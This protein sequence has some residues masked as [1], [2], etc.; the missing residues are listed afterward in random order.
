MYLNIREARQFP[1]NLKKPLFRNNN[2]GVFAYQVGENRCPHLGFNDKKSFCNIYENR[3]LCCKTFPVMDKG[4]GEVELSQ[5]CTV[6]RQNKNAVFSTE[7][8]K[9]EI[10]ALEEQKR[11]M[12]FIPVAQ[13]MYLFKIDKWIKYGGFKTVS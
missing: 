6:V 10:Q 2:D 12:D 9:D 11:E 3:P 13:E 7:S 4:N 1:N 5:L 8:L